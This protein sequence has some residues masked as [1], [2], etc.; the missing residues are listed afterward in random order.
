VISG[1]G[2]QITLKVDKP[3]LPSSVKADAFAVTV[4]STDSSNTRI[5]FPLQADLDPDGRTVKLTVLPTGLGSGL[6]RILVRGTGTVPLLGA[7]RSPL[8]GGTDAAPAPQGTD[9]VRLIERT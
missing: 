5:R 2:K 6:V 8:A 3:L 1:D 9:Y 7:D 4:F